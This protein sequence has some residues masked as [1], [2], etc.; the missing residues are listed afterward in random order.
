MDRERVE[1]RDEL[2]GDMARFAHTN[3]DKLATGSRSLP[4]DDDVDGGVEGCPSNGIGRVEICQC[5]QRCGLGIEDMNR[6]GEPVL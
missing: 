3:D 6:I 5:G 2:A 1:R 4:G